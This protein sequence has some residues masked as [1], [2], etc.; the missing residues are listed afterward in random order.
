MSLSAGRHAVQLGAGESLAFNA[1]GLEEGVLG[2][3]KEATGWHVVY[4]LGGRK[5][6]AFV[7][8]KLIK[9]FPLI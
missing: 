1:G 9:R 6:W 4:S 5:L 3:G 8:F 7:I 2:R